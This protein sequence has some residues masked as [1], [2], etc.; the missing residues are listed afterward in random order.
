MLQCKNISISFASKAL[1][2]DV[3]FVIQERERCALVGRNGSGKSTLFRVL[4]GELEADSGV[5]S[6]SRGTSVGYLSQ[7]ISFEEDTL[8]KEGA[9]GLPVGEKDAIYKV[10]R[11]LLGLGFSVKDFHEEPGSFSGGFQ[12]RLHLAKA[13][14]RQP[15][16]LLLD[17]PTNYLDILSIRWLKKVLKDWKGALIIVSHDR[18]FLDEVSTHTMG[19]HGG[20]LRKIGGGTRNYFE[21]VLMDEEVHE[22][23]R[24]KM[25]KKRE[26][27]EKFVKRF[28]SKAT[29]AAQ[30]QSKLK[31]LAKDPVLEK[32]NQ[33]ASLRFAF[34]EAPFPGKKMLEATGVSFSYTEKPLVEGFSLEL[35]K[36]QR[37]AV[38]GKNGRGKSTILKLLSGHLMPQKGNVKK[39]DN[40]EVGYFG[41]TNIDQLNPKCTVEEEIGFANS[42]LSVSEV[43]G[44]AGLMLFSGDD[45]SKKIEL[46]S[47]GEKSRVLLGKIIAKPC[48]LLL[49]DEPTHHLDIESI[50]A[51]VSAV[52]N[53]SG[54]VIIVTHSEMILKRIAFDQ[55]IV[56]EKRSQRVFLGGFDHFMAKVG[57]EEEKA[58]SEKKGGGH[59]YEKRKEKKRQISNLEKR[60]EKL[61]EEQ[62]ERLRLIEGGDTGL[63]LME[64]YGE[65]EKEIDRLYEELNEYYS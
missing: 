31:Q 12:L 1:F 22:K 48:N 28:G 57:W 36:N 29:K 14:L 59:S 6:F 8:L 18:D 27:V 4:S 55:L 45:A 65:I 62:K 9:R 19:F 63:E 17:E 60:I 16:F 52:E 46:L 40:L 32:L 5:I 58:L 64:K 61:E 13:L 35:L 11:A 2:E 38:I 43:K 23:T 39:P 44:I 33:M 34:S 47:G 49:L 24:V 41:Q 26:H 20:K 10:E 25:E 54:S 53:F 37:I 21:K 7:H 3:S 51:L 42:E 56:C 50:D 15:D 30:A